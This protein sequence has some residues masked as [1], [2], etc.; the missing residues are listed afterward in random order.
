ME[1][2]TN[3]N[4]TITKNKNKMLKINLKLA[5]LLNNTKKDFIFY[6][7]DSNDMITNYC[8]SNDMIRN[9]HFSNYKVISCIKP[10]LKT[11]TIKL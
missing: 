9:K 10:S 3:R 11:L 7:L 1:W 4:K 2:R 8:L 6:N 5:V